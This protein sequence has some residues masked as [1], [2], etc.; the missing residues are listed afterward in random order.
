M[1][2]GNGLNR[3]DIEIEGSHYWCQWLELVDRG[4]SDSTYQLKGMDYRL[5][6]LVQNS[7]K[8]REFDDVIIRHRGKVLLEARGITLSYHSVGF[9]NLQT[10]D[11]RM[12]MFSRVNERVSCM[13]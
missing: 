4:S 8:Q 5:I 13:F 6:Q 3:I 11:V 12:S 10:F 1:K 2:F 7:G 9:L